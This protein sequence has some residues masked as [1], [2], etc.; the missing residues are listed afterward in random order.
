MAAKSSKRSTS[1]STTKKSTTRKTVGKK[2]PSKKSTSKKTVSKKASTKKASTK[3]ASTKKASTKKA[4]TKKT[5]GRKTTSKKTASKKIVGKKT[6]TKRAPAPAVHSRKAGPQPGDT[7]PRFALTDQEGHLRS[8]GDYTG[9][10]LVLY[11]Y[12]KDDTSGC[13]A[14]SCQFR[15]ALPEFEQLDA[16]VLGVS[17]LGVKSK[18]KFAAKHGLNFPILADDETDSDGNPAP[19]VARDYGVW[20]T[21]SMYGRSYM[22]IERTTL[23]IGPDGVVIQRW[24]KVKVPGHA[25]DVMAALQNARAS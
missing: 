14:E 23:L 6:P 15:D 7:A 4:S 8:I 5:V 3:K 22:G 18:A 2:T 10:H 12:P 1:T 16:A 19:R 9:K 17:I 25:E 13:T 20:V 11:F 24:D 21:K